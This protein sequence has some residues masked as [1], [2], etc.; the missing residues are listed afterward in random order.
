MSKTMY[1][2]TACV[3]GLTVRLYATEQGLAALE[4]PTESASQTETR[5]SRRF[6]AVTLVRDDRALDL[7]RTALERYAQGPFVGSLPFDAGGTPFQ[8]LVW[9]ALQTIP[10]GT[11]ETYANV[12]RA[13]GRAHSVRAVAAA[14]AAN[15]VPILVPCHRIIGS[16][17][18]LTGYRGGLSL[19]SYLLRLEAEN[20]GRCLDLP[21]ETGHVG[22]T[23]F[24]SDWAPT[25]RERKGG[26]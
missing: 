26:F 1:W 11:T 21:R 5:L 2:D 16:N 19:K 4:L 24:T 15:P 3:A 9:E 7:Y 22:S 13:L 20:L 23:L 12:A 17:G 8:Q 14:I 6:G 25:C 10:Y 18:T